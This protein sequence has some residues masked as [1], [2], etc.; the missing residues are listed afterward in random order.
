[1]R[2][3]NRN[4]RHLLVLL[5]AQM[6]SLAL[7]FWIHH[8]IVV[9]MV[10]RGAQKAAAAE[11]TA[12]M[13]DLLARLDQR[14]VSD[15][16][17][18]PQGLGQI[19]RMLQGKQ[20]MPAVQLTLVDP[21]W[22]V[23]RVPLPS[24]TAAP[25]PSPGEKLVWTS[26]P[27]GSE[28]DAD[29]IVGSLEMPDGAHV[30]VACRWD[31]PEAYLVAHRALE[32]VKVP[33]EVLTGS[34][35]L[36]GTIAWFWTSVLL[37]IAVYLIVTRLYEELSRRRTQAEG[38][39]LKR[40]QSLVRTRDAVIFGLAKL[41]ESRDRTTGNH[42]ERISSYA[43]RLAATLRHHPKY[44]D[45][46]TPEFV[47]LI[48]ISSALHDIGKVG[49]ED[50]ILLKHGPLTEA[51]RAR[52]QQHTT[53]GARYLLDI[54]RRLGSSDFLQM[55]RQ[56]ALSHHERWDGKGYP[57]GL[58]GEA[59]P[60]A[61][62][63]VAVTDTYEALS[64]LSD[65]KPAIPHEECVKVIRREAGKQFDPDLVAAFFKVE[66]SFRRIASQYGND[67]PGSLRGAIGMPGAAEDPQCTGL[68]LQQASTVAMNSPS[69]T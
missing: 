55:A 14:D 30:A 32:N 10:S 23:L 36:A 57:E 26:P 35:A 4:L 59:I 64:S 8:R 53:I 15:R 67:A 2:W 44:R 31:G 52:V 7:G 61:A 21:D 43:S 34:L 65:Y 19:D 62:R 12:C 25:G 51:E 41:A 56:I 9:S 63:I 5:A 28:A 48:G 38:E 66:G 20:A 46:L 11:L 6:G 42:L 45:L 3:R 69:Q 24:D 33:P 13:D 40:I 68:A 60:L 54:E 1:M 17:A 22:R 27:E 49:I 37:G 58:A 18:R 29:R 47:Q 16:V 39:S 50:T